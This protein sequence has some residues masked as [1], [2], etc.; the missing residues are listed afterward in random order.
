VASPI[1]IATASPQAALAAG[2][3]KSAVM[4]RMTSVASPHGVSS[5]ETISGTNVGEKRRSPRCRSGATI[6]F[7]DTAHRDA[8]SET[9]NGADGDGV[10][11]I[12]LMAV[13]AMGKIN[14]SEYQV[15]MGIV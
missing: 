11:S 8:N 6:G 1:G 3:T 9:N 2:S 10:D 4:S 13:E 14:G 7:G 5:G 15:V 12:L